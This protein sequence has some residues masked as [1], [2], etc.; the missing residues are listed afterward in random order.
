MLTRVSCCVHIYHSKT[1]SH[2]ESLRPFRQVISPQA[3]RRTTCIAFGVCF[4]AQRISRR[5]VYGVFES[6]GY[7]LPV[8]PQNSRMSLDDATLTL[9]LILVFVIGGCGAAWHFGTS[10][11][12]GCFLHR[13][14]RGYSDTRGWTY[15]A[16]HLRRGSVVAGVA[17]QTA[18]ITKAATRIRHHQIRASLSG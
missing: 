11:Q 13:F 7:F 6:T 3:C 18:P 9:S 5:S 17:R 15:S 14:D 10:K 12:H 8:S 4:C 1:V 2:P 16:V